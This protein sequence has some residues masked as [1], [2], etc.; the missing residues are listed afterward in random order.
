MC[1][2]IIGGGGDD[3]DDHGDCADSDVCEGVVA[4]VGYND[5]A[6]ADDLGDG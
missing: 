1:A 5:G 6:S 2:C 3:L 4:A